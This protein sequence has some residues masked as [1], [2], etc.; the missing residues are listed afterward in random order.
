[1]LE[2]TA[3]GLEGKTALITGSGS[4]I[5]RGISVE[6]AKAG[7][8]IVVVD[9]NATG[10]AETAD[11]VR[12]TGRKA[13]VV[14][15]DVTKPESVDAMLKSTLDTFGGLDVLVN[16]VGGLGSKPKRISLLDLTFED[17]DFLMK[18][19][20]TSQFLCCKA[21]IQY[22]V[23]NGRK[24]SIV[25][26]ASLAAMVPYETSVVYA[27]AK[28]GV[29]SMTQTLAWEY[30]QKGIRVNSIAPGHVRTPI[31]V[32]LY[33]GKEDLLEAQ[34]RIIPLRRWGEPEEIGRLALFLASDA[35]SYVTGQTVTASGGMTYFRTSVL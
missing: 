12:E 35:A 6:M 26:I 8:D 1:M 27:A 15:A 29:V 25:N 3:Y 19:N 13:M 32:S 20:L 10:A 31:P 17:W 24:G 14:E 30:G 5:G 16:N 22:A 9:M 23:D 18:L 11:M 28:A 33:K 4:G 7:A 34:N 2:G 21:F